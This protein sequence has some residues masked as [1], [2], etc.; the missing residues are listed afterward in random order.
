MSR[1]PLTRALDRTESRR[2]QAGCGFALAVLAGVC[3]SGCERTTPPAG[4]TRIPP[5]LESRFYPPPGWTW[6]RLSLEGAPPF[7]YGVGIEPKAIRGVV[8]IL[9]GFG[10]PAEAWFE[11]AHE[12]TNEGYAV[13]VLDLAGQ[14]GS[15]RWAS[16]Q[17]KGHLTS[18][19]LNLD[20]VRRMVTQVIR[21]PP[22]M[23]FVLIGS[24][25]GGQ[26]AL[27]AASNGLPELDALI[28]SAPS[29]S[30]S[31]LTIPGPFRTGVIAEAAS[32]LGFDRLFGPEQS[33][34]RGGGPPG[35]SGRASVPQAWARANPE[36]RTGGATWGWIR[37]HEASVGAAR[38][39]RT[40]QRLSLPVLMLDQGGGGR[41]VCD[42]LKACRYVPVR[43][44][45]P[46]HLAEDPVRD[47]WRRALIGFI[48]RQSAGYA[49]AAAPVR[50]AT[51]P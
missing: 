45:A 24:D 14:G 50:T 26:V 2:D 43:K 29:L 23:P 21:P 22:G 1:I 35:A 34:W 47:E 18:M 37:A 15:G 4:A 31:A 11:T 32:E 51:A 42:A 6:S 3:L 7:R 40:L 8:L 41:A 16:T 10:E 9:P 27:R 39:P 33:K 44:G 36:L 20:A 48:A 17:E 38:S 19:Q 25:L 30:D 49:P 13:W 28:L 12:L 46:P 5:G